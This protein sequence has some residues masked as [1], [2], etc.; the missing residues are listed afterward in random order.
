MTIV[1]I[2][3]GFIVLS[4]IG[5]WLNWREKNQG[6]AIKQYVLETAELE[7]Q[8]ALMNPRLARGERL[9]PDEQAWLEKMLFER[10]ITSDPA[11][12]VRSDLGYD[13]ISGTLGEFFVIHWASGG[14]PELLE[15][16]SEQVRREKMERMIADI[17]M[18]KSQD[19]IEKWWS[20]HSM[21]G[22][23][24]NRNDPVLPGQRIY[25]AVVIRKAMFPALYESA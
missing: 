24:A 9:S 5:L 23:K 19:D 14:S 18:P 11:K 25:H 1:W 6:K 15:I 3:I 8:L 20:S 12:W 4:A 13:A 22:T 21:D 16:K 10:R 7:R 17:G 2:V